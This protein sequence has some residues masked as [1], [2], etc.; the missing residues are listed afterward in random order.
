VKRHCPLRRTSGLH[1]GK[2]MLL[3]RASEQPVFRWDE[4]YFLMKDG[5]ERVI[6]TVST[7]V[8]L[9]LGD[10]VGMNDAQMIFRAY[11]EEIERAASRKYVRT[12]REPYEILDI[13]EFR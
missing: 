5:D 9:A 2:A 1:W 13:G 10:T 4:I 7:R 8:L 11:R 12:A 6:C 3:A